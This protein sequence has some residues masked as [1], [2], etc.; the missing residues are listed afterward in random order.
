V[1]KRQGYF[2]VKALLNHNHSS[3]E[4]AKNAAADHAAG[5]STMSAAQAFLKPFDHDSSGDIQL[6]NDTGLDTGDERV[7]YDSRDR[8]SSKQVYNIWTDKW[9]TVTSS[10]QEQR[11]NSAAHTLATADA[12]HNGVVSAA[13]MAQL[14]AKSDV[15]RSGTLTDAEQ[16]A[17]AKAH[18]TF[19]GPWKRS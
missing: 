8:E 12:D 3:G 5:V 4:K 1:Y 11:G 16:A 7:F 14:M 17:F 9:H 19:V 10:W 18:P 6:V 2:G 15:D 13:E